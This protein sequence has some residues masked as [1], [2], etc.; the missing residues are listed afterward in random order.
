M[1]ILCPVG[2]IN[3]VNLQ[4]YVDWKTQQGIAVSVVSVGSG[5]NVANTTTAIKNYMQNLWNNATPQNPAPTYLLIIGD[6][7]GTNSIVTNIGTTNNT[8][9]ATDLHYVRLSGGDFMPEMY[10]GRFSVS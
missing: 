5:G 6:E 7:S 2:Y 1:V 10:H 4:N 9:H 8:S 3:N